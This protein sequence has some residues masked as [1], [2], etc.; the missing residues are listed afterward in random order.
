MLYGASSAGVA[1]RSSGGQAGSPRLRHLH[2][3]ALAAPRW[4]ASLTVAATKPSGMM[5]PITMA[6]DVSY[7]L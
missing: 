6:A 5:S 2:E 4:R 7:G 3:G 1:R